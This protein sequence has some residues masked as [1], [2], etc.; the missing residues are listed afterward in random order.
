[1]AGAP[2]GAS[3]PATGPGATSPATTQA[4]E[5][6]P[7]AALG[8]YPRAALAGPDGAGGALN[9][10]VYL[11]DAAR[12]FYRGSRFDWS[13]IVAEVR[14]N[15]HVFF[16][17]I[18]ERHDPL[19]HDGAQGTPEE[20]GMD[21]PLGY[22]EAGAGPP[23][24]WAGGAGETFVKIG[25]GELRR[26][27]DGKYAFNRSYE[28]ARAGEWKVRAERSAITFE[29][30]FAGPRGWAYRYVKVVALAGPNGAGDG[31][32][33]TIR[34]ALKNTGGKAIRTDHY[35]HNFVA[36]DGEA[37]L[38]P[39]WRVEFPFELQTESFKD[40]GVSRIEG[41]SLVFTGELGKGQSVF[42]VLKGFQKAEDAR[43]RVVS[44]KSGAAVT[45]RL[46]RAP[47]KMV[48]YALNPALCP[49]MFVAIDLEPGKEMEWTTTYE[50]GAGGMI[51]EWR[52]TKPGPATARR[53][54]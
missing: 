39:G 14:W 12:G 1:M 20:F 41:R 34:R 27:D 42:A 9:A 35:G 32:R 28:I 45:I 18:H 50:F 10:K 47:A 54:E 29:Q 7:Q 21:S 52:M 30:D 22:D 2:C 36:I 16:G 44:A 40:R 51:E 46:D 37:S 5:E 17:P 48:V 24:P 19:R 53:G 31:P 11:P 3:G 33:M 8:E 43:A 38:G 49:E 13:G 25:V 4:V 23:G 6:Y 26:P 15:G